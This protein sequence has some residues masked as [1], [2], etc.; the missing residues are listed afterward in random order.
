M[1]K[2]LVLAAIFSLLGSSAYGQSITVFGNSDAQECYMATK[3]GSG[4]SAVEVCNRALDA[5][6]LTPRDRAATLINRGINLSQ[7]GQ[8]GPA[9]EDYA[10]ALKIDAELAEA[11]LN[12]GNTYVFLGQFD[13]AVND[14]STAI[15]LETRKLHAAYFNRGLAYEGLKNLESAFADFSKALE[16]SPEW[17]L[18]LER[19]ERYQEY[20]FKN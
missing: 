8:H 9:L 1:V 4:G 12:R 7:S 16:L 14:Y 11:F 15:D 13:N 5:G 17:A 3:L 20:G 18:P 10:S 6:G 2:H 19:V